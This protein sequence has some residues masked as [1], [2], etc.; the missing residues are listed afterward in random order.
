MLECCEQ[1]IH[2]VG[3]KGVADF[4]S[5]ERNP[6]RSLVDGSMVRDVGEIETRHLPP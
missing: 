5:I 3:S 4:R 6:Y 2:G 1:F